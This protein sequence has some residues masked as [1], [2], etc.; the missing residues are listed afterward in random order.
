MS[1]KNLK[2]VF[3]DTNIFYNDWFLNSANL[4]YLFHYISNEDC[5][6]LISNIVSQEIEN[7]HQRELSS[8]RDELIRQWKKL[9]KLNDQVLDLKTET[10]DIVYDFKKLLSEKCESVIFIPYA[11]V[12]HDLLVQKALHIQKPFL[13]GE[14]GY[15]DA[16]I[17]IS[18]L[19]FLSSNG[20][21][22][23]V[24]F[25]TNN[26]T[27]FLSTSEKGLCLHPHLEHDVRL[28]GVE[29]ELIAYDSLFRFVDAHIDKSAHSV[30]YAKTK[31]IA[32]EFL[33]ER[34]IDYLENSSVNLVKVAFIEAGINTAIVNEILTIDV[35]VM[36]GVEGLELLTHETFDRS[37]V[38]L[39]FDYDL[40]IV[41]L[42]F[43]FPISAYFSNKEVM[44]TQ[45]LNVE[46][47]D[48][49]AN[50]GIPLRVYLQASCIF[51]PIAEEFTNFSVVKFS[52]RI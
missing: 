5:T 38:F 47:D 29:A 37:N 48:T 11:D 1:A 40:R 36:E 10:L 9:K 21:K 27:D 28:L 39:Y 22:E 17:W 19:K 45:L 51:N 3:L 32:E 18:L 49:Y 42:N 15:R 26:K 44:D 8:L 46:I 7:I 43:K 6:L 16:L 33:E 30:D 31:Y 2:Y 50:A 52:C 12:P 14:K 24:A 41:Y 25:I 20:I 23:N 4:R 13:E 34:A 35:D